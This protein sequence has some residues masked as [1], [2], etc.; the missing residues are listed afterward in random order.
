MTNRVRRSRAAV[1]SDASMIRLRR[2]READQRVEEEQEEFLKL[3]PVRR[4]PRHL[5]DES[6]L[7][8][9]RD[10]DL[11]TSVEVEQ[12]DLHVVVEVTRGSVSAEDF[13][14]WMQEAVKMYH[15]FRHGYMDPVLHGSAKCPTVYLAG[16]ELGD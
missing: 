9:G 14:N 4:T 5:I 6:K 3:P 15:R 1:P 7:P 12:F 10:A 8:A 11:L 16:E 13:K 2:M